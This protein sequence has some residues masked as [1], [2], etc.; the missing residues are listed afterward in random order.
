MQHKLLILL[1]SFDHFFTKNPFIISTTV[2]VN[3]FSNDFSSVVQFYSRAGS[4]FTNSLLSCYVFLMRNILIKTE[5]SFSM[6]SDHLN[7]MLFVPRFFLGSRTMSRC[8]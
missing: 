3:Y 5:L 1:V 4:S 6:Q 2:Q 8:P 7:V